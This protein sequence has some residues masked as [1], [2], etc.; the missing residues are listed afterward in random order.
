LQSGLVPCIGSTNHQVISYYQIQDHVWG[1]TSNG[2]LSG[3]EVAFLEAGS[4]KT[5]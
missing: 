1:K 5:T 3:P 4:D 2:T